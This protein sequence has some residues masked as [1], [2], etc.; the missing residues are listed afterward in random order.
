LTA[1]ELFTSLSS[2]IVASG[3]LPLLEIGLKS[4]RDFSVLKSHVQINQIT[5]AAAG[6]MKK[7]RG[8]I[9]MEIA[10]CRVLYILAGMSN[11]AKKTIRHGEA[12]L[13]VFEAAR[14]SVGKSDELFEA[15]GKVLF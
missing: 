13:L 7:H 2:G 5:K 6:A 8:N 14:N 10:A 9:C 15:A 1:K 11:E 4:V 3:L 12:D